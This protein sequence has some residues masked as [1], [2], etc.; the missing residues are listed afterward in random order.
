MTRSKKTRFQPDLEHLDRRDLPALFTGVTATLADGILNVS[1]SN[2]NSVIRIDLMGRTVRGEVRGTVTVQGVGRFQAAQIDAIEVEKAEQSDRVVIRRKGRWSPPTTVTVADTAAT[3]TPIPTPTPVRPPLFVPTPPA[4]VVTP[5]V[6]TP[7]VVVTPPASPGAPIPVGVLLSSTE[8]EIVDLT[9]QMRVQNGLAPLTVNA[10]LVTMADIEA[11]NMVQFNIMAHTIPQA[12]Q[13][14]L[15]SRQ[16]YVG[17][18]YSWLSENIAYNFLDA[19][20]VVNGWMGSTGHR[21]NI[22][23]SKVTEIGV[24]VLQDSKGAPYYVQV[25]GAPA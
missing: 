3:A 8:Q 9:N 13:P 5:P 25:F 7:P 19:G 2:A 22:L 24:A 18:S 15:Q 10:Q 6:V 1:G 23:D 12:A 21:A 20:S 14:D 16:K 17:Y 4:P 11:G